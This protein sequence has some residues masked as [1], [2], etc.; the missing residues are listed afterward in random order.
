MP[1]GPCATR[2][3]AGLRW[4]LRVTW[5]GGMRIL[6]T[7]RSGRHSTSSSHRPTLG[8]ARRAARW[9]GALLTWRLRRSDASSCARDA[10]A[11]DTNFYYSFLVLPPDKRRAIVAVWDFCRAVDDAVDE[12]GSGGARAGQGG[13][14][15][16]ASWRD[17]F[18]GGTPQTPQGRA[19]QPLV[20][21]VQPAAVGV[22]RVDRRRRDGSRSPPLRDVRRARTSTASAVASAVGLICVEIFGYRDP[23]RAQYAIDLGVALQL[24]NI[25]RDVP[26]DLRAGRVYLPARGSRAHRRHARTTRAPRSATPGSGVRSTAV[27]ALLAAA[28]GRAREYY[29]GRPRS[30]RAADARRLGRR[31]NHGRDLPRHPRPHRARRLRRVQPGHPRA[32]SAARADCGASRWAAHAARPETGRRL[33]P[34][35]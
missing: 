20:G 24:T 2:C 18:D 28:G 27:K 25:L 15:G 23:R 4:E 7:P 26:E 6:D 22:R 13:A 11:R 33:M 9:R 3:A 32:A 17:C 12:A 10:M 19:L 21:A 31:R 30:C 5:L 1:G 29:A 16:G 8:A 35:A 34:G 14:S